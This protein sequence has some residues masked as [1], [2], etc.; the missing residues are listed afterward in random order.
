M[1]V[2]LYDEMRDENQA[3]LV[4]ENM[5]IDEELAATKQ[6]SFWNNINNTHIPVINFNCDQIIHFGEKTTTKES[7]EE[8]LTIND[9]P[10][11]VLEKILIEAALSIQEWTKN[12]WG[13]IYQ[14]LSE[15]SL[16]WKAIV[17]SPVFS[18]RVRQLS[19]RREYLVSAYFPP[20]K[21][22]RI[23]GLSMGNNLSK[24]FGDFRIHPY[25]SEQSR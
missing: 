3:M 23:G 5:T 21:R 13:C 2:E 20:F 22:R 10:P 6:F 19:E 25:R 14:Q 17:D 4:E 7:E 1:E 24:F 18:L 11:E 15:V 12:S 9:L 8:H 16:N